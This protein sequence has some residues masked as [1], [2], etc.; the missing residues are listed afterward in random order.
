[1]YFRDYAIQ[2]KIKCINENLV[3]AKL[4]LAKHNFLTFLK[5]K[6]QKVTP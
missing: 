3:L 2:K 5:N 4:Q 6:T 1:M